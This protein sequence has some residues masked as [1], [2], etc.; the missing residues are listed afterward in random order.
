MCCYR[1]FYTIF[2]WAAFCLAVTMQRKCTLEPLKM[3]LCSKRNKILWGTLSALLKDRNVLEK[4][5]TEIL[6]VIFFFIFF[7]FSTN[8]SFGFLKDYYGMSK[9]YYCCVYSLK[10]HYPKLVMPICTNKQK[11]ANALE[12][13]RRQG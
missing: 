13:Q 5:L 7:Y 11:Q 10:N 1:L 9:T 6:F 4:V 3:R 8:A 12:W 2:D